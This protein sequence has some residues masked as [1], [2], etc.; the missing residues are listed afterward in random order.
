MIGTLPGWAEKFKGNLGPF[1]FLRVLMLGHTAAAW[2][3]LIDLPTRES[4]GTEGQL[5]TMQR[6]LLRTDRTNAGR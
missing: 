6:L 4:R 2:T 1:L 3:A 5:Q